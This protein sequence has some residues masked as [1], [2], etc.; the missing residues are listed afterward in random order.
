MGDIHVLPE[1]ITG[2][3]AYKD[4]VDLLSLIHI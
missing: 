4:G 1:R 2:Y 3:R